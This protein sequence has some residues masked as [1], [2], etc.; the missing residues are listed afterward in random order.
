MRILVTGA[1]GFLGRP[2]VRALAAAGHDAGALEGDVTEPATFA[3][4]SRD[5]KADVAYHLA[6]QSNVPQ[7]AKDPAGTWKANVDGTLQVLEWARRDAVGRVVVVSSSHVYGH[8]QRSPIDEGHPLQPRS[9]YGASKMAA[10]ALALAYHATY[11]VPTV[12]VRPF[13]IYGP[14]QAPGFL[15]PDIVRQ[16]RAGKGLVLGDPKPVRDYTYID[17]AVRFFLACGTVSAPAVA[18]E[19]INLGS[20]K[21]QSVEQ[22][23]HAAIKASGSPLKPTFAASRFR[24]NES[25]A[26]VADASKAKRLLGWTPQ[27][28]LEDGLRQTWDAG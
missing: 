28:G 13:N 14:G 3:K 20:G 18:G 16:L 9:P 21:G 10:E 7:S 11:G 17:D 24:A 4:A 23:V 19:A 1:G 26:V 27:I 5:G 22:I 12:I 2:L 15:V 6:A 8:P 25:G